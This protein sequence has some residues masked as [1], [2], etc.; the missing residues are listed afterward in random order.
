MIEKGAIFQCVSFL[1]FIS[2]DEINTS[3]YYRFVILMI[4]LVGYM[5]K[6]TWVGWLSIIVSD[7]QHFSAVHH[8]L[9]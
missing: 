5:V 3:Y 1:A 7:W 6:R 2:V 8:F 4:P 9:E